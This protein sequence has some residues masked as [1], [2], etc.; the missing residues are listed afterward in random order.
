MFADSID[1]SDYYNDL[2]TQIINNTAIFCHE[3]NV[4]DAKYQCLLFL[5][6]I[7]EWFFLKEKIIILLPKLYIIWIIYLSPL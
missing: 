7:M 2:Y 3:L 6:F 5:L 4:H 1:D